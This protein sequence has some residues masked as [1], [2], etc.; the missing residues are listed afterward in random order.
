VN[1]IVTKPSKTARKRSHVF[2]DKKSWQ[3]VGH[4]SILRQ[5]SHHAPATAGRIVAG[6]VLSAFMVKQLPSVYQC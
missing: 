6:I 5:R 1:G 4:L 3:P 2:V